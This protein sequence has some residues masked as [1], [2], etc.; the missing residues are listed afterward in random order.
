MQNFE[1]GLHNLEG[2]SPKAIKNH[3]LYLI[4]KKYA[5]LVGQGPIVEGELLAEF[6]YDLTQ[7][8]DKFVF[9]KVLNFRLSQE[10][11][12]EEKMSYIKGYLKHKNAEWDSKSLK[13]NRKE[14]VLTVDMFKLFDTGYRFWNPLKSL[15]SYFHAFSYLSFSR[16]VVKGMPDYKDEKFIALPMETLDVSDSSNA[17]LKIRN[18]HA[19]QHV[20]RFVVSKKVFDAL[21][22]KKLPDDVKIVTHKN[23]IIFKKSSL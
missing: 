8:N 4:A 2:S 15:A 13:M 9:F 10:M 18:I 1:Q 5:P 7:L 3:E 20:K 21:D 6:I 11:S 14:G 19:F 17:P 23:G 16:I 22:E 12:Y